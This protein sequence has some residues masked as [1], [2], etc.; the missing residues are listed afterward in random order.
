MKKF[1]LPLL[2]VVGFSPLVSA[3]ES[4]DIPGTPLGYDSADQMFGYSRFWS[5]YNPY[6]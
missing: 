2:L 4:G 1:L 5:Y 6:P 3:R